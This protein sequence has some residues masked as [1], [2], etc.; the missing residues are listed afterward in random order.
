LP[1]DVL[2]ATTVCGDK[3][4]EYRVPLLWSVRIAHEELAEAARHS[5]AM[6]FEAEWPAG[7]DRHELIGAVRVQKT[8][9]KGRYARFFDR[10]LPAIE[11]TERK[12]WGHG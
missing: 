4:S 8:A 7:V 6:C 1:V 12:G 3:I 9:V 11:I 2:V 5:F 10:Q